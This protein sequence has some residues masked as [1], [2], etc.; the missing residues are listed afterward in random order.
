MNTRRPLLVLAAA[1]LIAVLAAPAA[2]AHLGEAELNQTRELIA[3]GTSCD[4][5][6]TEQLIGI[7]EYY[8]EQIHPGEQHE[9]MD[10]H[11]GGENATA[12]RDAHLAMAD[13]F[14]CTSVGGSAGTWDSTSWGWMPMMGTWGGGGMMA[15]FGGLFW[16]AAWILVILGIVYLALRIRDE[17]TEQDEE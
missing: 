11:L 8:M 16:V 12:Y 14:Y 17:V 15:G 1:A 5:L 10:Q 13:R 2:S 7:G 9:L 6:T 3:Q 4:V